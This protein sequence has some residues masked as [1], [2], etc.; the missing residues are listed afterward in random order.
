MKQISVLLVALV[1]MLFAFSSC[2]T[3]AQFQTS[4]IVPAARGTVVVKKDWNKNYVIKIKLY[5]LAE[6]SRLTPPRNSYVVWMEAED[7]G[8]KNLGKIKSASSFMSKELNASF[9]TVTPFKPYKIF[10]T[11]E[12]DAMIQFP[13]TDVV[14]TTN[15]L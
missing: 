3:K 15:H 12:D 2:A 10:I 13:V 8:V 9:E 7:N 4:S 1:A 11:A 14:L 5:N 6:S